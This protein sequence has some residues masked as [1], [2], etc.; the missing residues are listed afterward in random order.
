MAEMAPGWGKN[1]CRGLRRGRSRS[2][3]I[4][5]ELL[6]LACREPEE[7]CRMELAV[8]QV[9]GVMKTPWVS[10]AMIWPIFLKSLALWR[11]GGWGKVVRE[12]LPYYLNFNAYFL[13]ISLFPNKF[14]WMLCW[15]QAH[16][17]PD[18]RWWAA[19]LGPPVQ[20]WIEVA[21]GDIFSWF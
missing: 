9:W 14:W 13:G 6:G 12:W 10:W 15:H 7:E 3:R 5:K 4:W 18:L 20:H 16:A 2:L 17:R 8:R 1:V 21:G 11:T 19:P